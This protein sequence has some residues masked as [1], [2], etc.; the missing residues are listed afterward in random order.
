MTATNTTIFRVDGDN[1]LVSL[2]TTDSNDMVLT[3]QEERY[4]ELLDL[5]YMLTNE[6]NSYLVLEAGAPARGRGA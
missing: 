6:S 3:L 2:Q 5:T 4:G 1:D